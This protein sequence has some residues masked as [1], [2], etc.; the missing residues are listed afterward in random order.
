MTAIYRNSNKNKHLTLEERL[1]RYLDKI[2][3]DERFCTSI[4]SVGD[5]LSISVKK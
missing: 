5:G 4:L 2:T 1:H 3:K